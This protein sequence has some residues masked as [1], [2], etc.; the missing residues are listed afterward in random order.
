MVA[1]V[2]ALPA[3]QAR[4]GR[5]VHP[6]AGRV[7]LPARHPT[8]RHQVQAHRRISLHRVPL[9]LLIVPQALRDIRAAAIQ[10]RRIRSSA[11]LNR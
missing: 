1:V 6:P 5:R 11:V 10:P 9:D 7:H 4:L 2:T 3:A 8:G